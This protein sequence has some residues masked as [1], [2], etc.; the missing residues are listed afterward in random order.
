[1]WKEDDGARGGDVSYRVGCGLR[2]R[3]KRGLLDVRAML[4]LS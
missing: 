3:L 4:L 2:P 1:M